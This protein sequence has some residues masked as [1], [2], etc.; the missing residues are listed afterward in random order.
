MTRKAKPQG[1]VIDIPTALAALKGSPGGVKEWHRR[2]E[3]F[4]EVET[5]DGWAPL[6]FRLT[7]PPEARGLDARGLAYVGGP[8]ITLMRGPH[9]TWLVHPR[10]VPE[11]MAMRH[12]VSQITGRDD[13]PYSIGGCARR[14]LKWIS[15]PQPDC[16]AG[17]P[18]G[19]GHT[20]QYQHLQP[21]RLDHAR[22]FDVRSCY[23]SILQRMPSPHVGT[24]RGRP[25]FHPLRS[26][27]LE[28]WRKLLGI[29]QHHKSLRNVLVGC[30]AGG[31]KRFCY[32]AG[33]PRRWPTPMGPLRPAA[34]LVVRT[35]YERC[36]LACEEAEAVYSNV[37]NVITTHHLP[38]RA[39]GDVGLAVRLEAEGD[40]D[41]REIGVYRVGGYA[42]RLYDPDDPHRGEPTARLT[43]REEWSRWM[44]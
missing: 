27:D 30:M 11:I 31:G 8:G 39:W 17:T 12:L 25:E 2:A 21:G 22:L 9:A 3:N 4:Y 29:L 14:L 26:S 15:I 19:V 32:H 5:M 13:V 1:R 6:A 43:V 24:L 28:E 10:A 23:F 36:A 16:T 41:V 38:P 33:H 40:A 20:W 35:A 42:T 7:A 44:R 18:F 37:D 34:L